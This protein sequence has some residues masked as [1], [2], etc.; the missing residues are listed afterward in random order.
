MRAIH[1][2]G[3]MC[4]LDGWE[5]GLKRL[6]AMPRRTPFM[7]H[8]LRD[9]RAFWR[10]GWA[11]IAAAQGWGTLDLFG[12]HPRA[13]ERRGDAKGLVCA[14]RGRAVARLAEGV[15]WIAIPGFDPVIIRDQ[16]AD[17]DV[18]SP[19]GIRGSVRFF[20]GGQF[21][22]LPPMETVPVWELSHG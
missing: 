18:A 17:A 19:F 15:A 3:E 13:P 22:G 10:D 4:P 7:D 5:A 16:V 14:L 12:A 6:A 8:A 1:A 2:T 11:A 20:R 21:G 9:A